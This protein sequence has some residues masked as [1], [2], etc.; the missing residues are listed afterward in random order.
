M[1]KFV[2]AEEA[3]KNIP[4]G[5]TIATSGF[6]G[7]LV[8]EG[9]LK[10]VQKSFIENNIPKD[11]TIIYAAGQGDGGERGLNHLGEEGLLKCIIGGHFNLTPKLGKLIMDEKV[12]AYNL[13]QGTLSQWFRDVAGRRPGTITK[14]G[15]GTFVDPRLEGGRINKKTT[16]DIVKVVNIDEEEWLLYPSRPIDVAIIRGTTADEDGNITLDGEVGTGEVLAIAEAAKASNG[17]V[18]AQVKNIATRGTL[19]PK[20][21]KVP[22]VIVDYVVQA[23]PEDHMMTWGH[24]FNPLYNGDIKAPLGALEKMPLSNRK[25]IARR[26]A[27]ELVPNAAVNLGI[28]MPEGVASIAAE[29]GI[30]D[31]LTLTTEAGTIGGVPAGGSDFGAST[32][33]QVI[34]DQPYQFDYYDGGNLDLA[35]LGL[36]ECDSQGNINVSKF[37]GRVAGCGGF[38]NIT[39][40]SKKVVYCGTFTAGGLKEEIKDG[41][42]HIINEGSSIKFLEHVE[43]V[44]F[45]GKYAMTVSQ[46]VLYVTERAVFKL[47]SDGLELTEVAPGVDIDKDIL[48]YMEFK[49]IMKNVKLMDNRIFGEEVMGLVL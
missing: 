24:E 13:P 9:I 2:G 6:V 26:C 3:V 36:A 14:V 25:I 35:I 28:G 46:P 49:P 23:S 5:A 48:Q 10:Q 32:N 11:L 22:G 29:E 21:V 17:I 42:L 41:E 43:Q 16:E 27:M 19:D 45:S 37:H 18:I 15:L 8:P 30:G 44:T 38:I 12:Y 39:Q 1:V 31:Q 40:N 20:V 34:L 7:A 4:N 33:A 47:T